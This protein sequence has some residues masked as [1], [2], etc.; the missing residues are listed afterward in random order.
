ML[1][2]VGFD[3][4]L[5]FFFCFAFLSFF[6]FFLDFGS[7]TIALE[8]VD[9]SICTTGCSKGYAMTAYCYFC[10]LSSYAFTSMPQ[11]RP[12]SLKTGLP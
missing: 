7:F 12:S 9:S 6:Y 10:G 11:H 5:D 8:S 4:L 3:F 2:A 1:S